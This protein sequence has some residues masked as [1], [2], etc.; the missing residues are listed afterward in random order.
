M[1]Q[2]SKKSE[3]YLESFEDDEEDFDEEDF[4]EEDYDE[5]DFDIYDEGEFDCEWGGI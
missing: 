4:D 3:T 5:E 1:E 2:A